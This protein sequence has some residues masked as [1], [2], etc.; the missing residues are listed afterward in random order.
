MVQLGRKG[1]L[2]GFLD[3]MTLMVLLITFLIIEQFSKSVRFNN[4]RFLMC[5][6]NWVNG[7]YFSQK[8]GSFRRKICAM[9]KEVNGTRDT[10]TT[11]T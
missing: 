8:W 9:K 4:R 7:T 5:Q 6:E 11:T 3:S 1:Q 10:V 2:N